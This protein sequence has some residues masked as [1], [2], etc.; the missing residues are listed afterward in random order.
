[1]SR[2]ISVFALVLIAVGASQVWPISH[3]SGP[4]PG[5]VGFGGQERYRGP[6]IDPGR[7][8]V[9]LVAT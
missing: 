9:D 1:M 8:V 3:V 7:V 4:A 2:F 6:G 5:P